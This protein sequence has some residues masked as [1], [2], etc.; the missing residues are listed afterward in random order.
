[1][2]LKRFCVWAGVAAALWGLGAPAFADINDYVHASGVLTITG[3]PEVGKVLTPSGVP[4]GS[5]CIWFRNGS[6]Q[7]STSCAPYMVQAADVG[8]NLTLQVTTSNKAAY[9]ALTISGT[10]PATGT[11]GTAYS[12]TPTITNG[13]GGNVCALSSNVPGLS[14]TSC[15]LGG[16]PTTAGTYAGLNFTAT[17]SVGGSASLSPFTIT[18]S[19]GVGGSSSFFFPSGSNLITAAAVF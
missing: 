3:A 1:M 10:P 8:T 12:F 19:G 2:K 15:V 18:V 4:T 7:V 17:D 5:A 11:V 6:T 16:T 13:S 14:V 9:A